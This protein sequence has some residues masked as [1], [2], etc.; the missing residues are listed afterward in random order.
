[1]APFIAAGS[2]PFPRNPN[3]F[4]PILLSLL[5]PFPSLPST[6]PHFVKPFSVQTY[7]DK[8][9]GSSK[10]F[11]AAALVVNTIFGYHLTFFPSLF[12]G[13]TWWEKEIGKGAGLKGVLLKY[14]LVLWMACVGICL[15][16]CA[17]GS[18]QST[19]MGTFGFVVVFVSS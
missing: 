8:V 9:F 5:F 3:G 4:S 15:W 6:H 17:G 18:Q 14:P 16:P 13:Q 11:P 19:H 7:K 12:Y 1:M 10:A 2:L